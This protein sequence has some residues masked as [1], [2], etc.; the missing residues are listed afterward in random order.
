MSL[1]KIKSVVYQELA[2]GILFYSNQRQVTCM[3]H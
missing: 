1:T 3:G 2:K